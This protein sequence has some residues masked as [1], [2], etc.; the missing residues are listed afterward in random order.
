MYVISILSVILFI[1]RAGLKSSGN[2]TP[3]IWNIANSPTYQT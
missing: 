1:L 3:T 2:K